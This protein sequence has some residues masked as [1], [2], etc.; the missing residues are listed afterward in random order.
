MLMTFTM[1]DGHLIDVGR[2]VGRTDWGQE[3]HM[4]N[5]RGLVVDGYTV[6]TVL[7]DL[8][9]TFEEIAALGCHIEGE[10]DRKL[11]PELIAVWFEEEK[12]EREAGT[13]KGGQA[14]SK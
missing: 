5:T 11:R 2:P 12:E 9:V 6:I 7:R 3:V 8:G 4:R 14:R 1:P 13:P 10:P